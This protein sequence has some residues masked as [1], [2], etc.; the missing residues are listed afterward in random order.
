[1]KRGILLFFMTLLLVVLVACGNNEEN[2]NDDSDT[3]S[4]G[5]SAETE[6]GQS[7][8]PGK[9]LVQVELKDTEGKKIGTAILD[10]GD[11]GVNI[12]LDAAK[13]PEGK[14]GFHIHEKAACETPD[15]ESAG[16]HFNPDD[17]NHGIDDPDGPHAGDLPNI[18]VN[19][20]GSVSESF[21]AKGVT[22]E[23]NAENSLLD[24]EGTSL[25]IH[26][27]EDDNKSQPSGDA[28][29]RIACGVIEE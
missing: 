24:G 23:K 8:E 27:D 21:V 12:Q 13:I 6:E 20:D 17:T 7:S 16:G 15:F 3:K 29:D 26:A 28:G 19:E 22:L 25:V 5:E 1:M 18:E 4:K 10:E 9:D 11:E 2:T 14:H